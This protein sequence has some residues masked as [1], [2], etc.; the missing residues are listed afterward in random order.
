MK[1]EFS[2]PQAST[3]RLG[4]RLS[5]ST[6]VIGVVGLTL[7]AWLVI[8]LYMTNMDNGPGTSLHTLPAFLFSWFVMLTAMML[9]SELNYIGVFAAVL[10]VRGRSSARRRHAM[11]S[12]L[13]GYGVT[14]ITYGFVAYLLDLLV[15]ATAPRIITWDRSGPL[16][17]GLVLIIAGSYQVSP[18]KHACLA[19]CRSPLSFFARHWR[20]GN[21]GA[22]AMGA[23]HGIVCVGCCWAM[24]GVM[25]A[26]GAMSLTWMGLLTL[27][28]FGEK[29]LPKGKTL[30][31]PIAC[32]FWAIGIWVAVSPATA[33]LL[34][35]PTMLRAHTCEK[36]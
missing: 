22:I 13:V 23:R 6:W 26:V 36:H 18:L 25:F 24:M 4:P 19:G 12:F 14:W 16:L 27:F 7:A 5:A 1:T 35:L 2:A 11:A 29:I 3:G 21:L 31:V 8:L 28:M 32:F 33:P 30:T 17:T 10:R 15:R 9:P 34:K 20:E